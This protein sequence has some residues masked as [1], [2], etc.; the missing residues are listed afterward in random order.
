[1]WNICDLSRAFACKGY[2]VFYGKVFTKL[3]TC[4][5]R[6]EN[7]FTVFTIFLKRIFKK[8]FDSNIF[9]LCNFSSFGFTG[10][11]SK[12]LSPIRLKQLNPFS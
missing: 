11:H 6:R 8:K 5:K 3:L 7:S 4:E 12:L 2:L 1:M 9:L 10:M